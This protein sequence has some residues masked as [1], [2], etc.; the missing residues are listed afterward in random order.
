VPTLLEVQHA[1]RRRLLDDADPGAVAL[2]A[3]ALAPADR[4]SIYRNTSRST[5]TNALRLTYPA[6][7]RLVGD[8]FFAAAADTFITNAPPRTAWLDVYGSGFPEFL[9]SF[10]PAAALF[11]LADVACLEWAIGRV[12]HAIDGEPLA[13]GQL[14]SVAESDQLRVCF[15]PHPAVSLVSS[16][17][18]V[19]AI[20]RAVVE[21]D[22]AALAAINLA[23]G[24]V[25]L[26]IERNANGIEVAR[27]DEPRWR[28]AEALFRGRP[29]SV[30]LEA[31]A[32]PEAPRWLAGHL[33]AG[34]FGGFSLSEAERAPP[35]VAELEQ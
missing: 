28:F 20:W 1:I 3:D 26:L 14:A 29:L 30:A 15:E 19:D 8:D 16:D 9:R 22:D 18:P 4:L 33:A 25:W 11:Y 23:A 10:K 2:L 35:V 31:A 13:L 34:H 32:N 6:V 5:L 27:L 12:L 17:Y 7:Q 21:R 24:A